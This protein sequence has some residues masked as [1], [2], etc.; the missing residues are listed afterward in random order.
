MRLTDSRTPMNV[1]LPRI[2]GAEVD[3]AC[4]AM[5]G[6]RGLRASR[7]AGKVFRWAPPKPGTSRGVPG[8]TL[9][10]TVRRRRSLQGQSACWGSGASPYTGPTT[11]PPAGRP[12]R[13]A[14]RWF[15]Q[16]STVTSIVSL[17]G[18]LV[19]GNLSLAAIGTPNPHSRRAAGSP[20][21]ITLPVNRLP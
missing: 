18:G 5:R 16:R 1:K 13:S 10:L 12:L 14:R 4:T 11:Y 6:P 15:V 19:F 2:I 7:T 8:P 20:E 3:L 17:R 21:A 9:R